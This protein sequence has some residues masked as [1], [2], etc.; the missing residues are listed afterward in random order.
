VNLGSASSPN[1]G[2]VAT[3]DKLTLPRDGYIYV[4]VQYG[5]V[6]VQYGEWSS[7]TGHYAIALGEGEVESPHPPSEE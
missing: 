6:K 5:Y 1:K 3:L 2:A 7:K 4:K